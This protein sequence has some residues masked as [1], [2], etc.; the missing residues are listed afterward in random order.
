M[1]KVLDGIR[2]IDIG[3]VQAAPFCCQILADF[4]AE[5]LRLEPPGGA[6]DRELGPFAPNGENLGITQ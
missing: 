6:V 4:G 5:V 1:A 3:T 2:V